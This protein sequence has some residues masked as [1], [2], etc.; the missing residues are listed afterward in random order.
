MKNRRKSV[1]FLKEEDEQQPKKK[2]K[3]P[4]DSR[5]RVMFKD[6]VNFKGINHEY[7]PSFNYNQN[8]TGSIKFLSN[9][10]SC[11][12]STPYPVLLGKEASME[13]YDVL[14]R[15]P[16]KFEEDRLRTRKNKAVYQ[17]CLK[18]KLKRKA[19]I[20]DEVYPSNI[21][22]F[23]ETFHFMDPHFDSMYDDYYTGGNL[24]VLRNK[25]FVLHAEGMNLNKLVC[26]SIKPPTYDKKIQLTPVTSLTTD[27]EI[28]E[29]QTLNCSDGDSFLVRQKHQIS[30]NTICD[31][32]I[33]MIH[34]LTSPKSPFMSSAQDELR[35][36]RLITTDRFQNFKLWN[37]ATSTADKFQF[38]ESLNPTSSWNMIR[39]F[40]R[41]VFLFATKDKI[42]RYDVRTNPDESDVFEFH[43][44]F[45]FCSRIS[46]LSVS[47][48]SDM[49]HLATSHKLLT[50][51]SR[52]LEKEINETNCVL[53]WTHQMDC[54]ASILKTFDVTNTDSEMIVGASPLM[55]EMRMFELEKVEKKAKLTNTPYQYFSSSCLP[56][57]PPTLETAYNISRRHGIALDPSYELKDRIS[58]CLSGLDFYDGGIG[59]PVMLTS[60]SIGDVFSTTL[61]FRNPSSKEDVTV[62]IKRYL[63]LIPE[64]KKKPFYATDKVDFSGFRKVLNCPR[65]NDG[66]VKIEEEYEDIEKVVKEKRCGRWKKPT[67]T[68]HEYK[69]M[70]AQDILS[71]WDVPKPD[72]LM[73]QSDITLPQQNKTNIVSSWLQSS[74]L[75]NDSM[76]VLPA[77]NNVDELVEPK[78]TSTP[79]P[80]K[81]AKKKKTKTYIKGF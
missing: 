36:S 52:Y 76:V 53:R 74:V 49:F 31:G 68:L 48:Y 1:Y 71:I 77:S 26:S 70:L 75:N 62:P 46:N 69:D 24:C 16:K 39:F 22:S 28:F 13:S 33:E 21:F 55:G 44:G 4:K 9:E 42:R 27:D 7:C 54:C 81:S 12:I 32:E 67:Q 57:M 19:L 38:D 65:L 25:E 72:E 61:N 20:R 37:L 43:D 34:L 40:Q 73:D 8:R 15:R 63:E 30:I 10:P 41:D 80:T 66:Y 17:G 35:R 29:I 45:E 3:K 14:F 79:V 18:K 11:K 5:F 60:N 58:Y 51:D 59:D 6:D 56:F 50:L 23:A 47:N 64:C 78:I 2:F